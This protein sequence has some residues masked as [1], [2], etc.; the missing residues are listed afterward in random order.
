MNEPM[1]EQDYAAAAARDGFAAEYMY[2]GRGSRRPSWQLAFMLAASV[3]L[4]LG[5]LWLYND[6]AAWEADPE[7]EDRWENAGVAL[8]YELGGKGLVRGVGVGL[9]ALT[10]LLAVVA[11]VRARGVVRRG[12]G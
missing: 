2:H 4:I 8:L 3:F 9:G 5:S 6:F 12:K 10:G 1:T 11:Y 7:A